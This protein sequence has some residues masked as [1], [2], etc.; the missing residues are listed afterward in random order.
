MATGD[1]TTRQG[2]DYAARVYVA[3]K[4]DPARA[5]LW[6]RTKFRVIRLLYRVDPPRAV[7]NYIWASRLPKGQ[8]MTSPHFDQ[9]TMVAVESGP[10]KAGRWVCEGRNV[11]DDYLRLFGEAPTPLSG[12]AIMT[13]TDNTGEDAVAYYADL[14]LYSQ[15]A[16]TRLLGA[17]GPAMAP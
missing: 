10:E 4:F 13:D 5:T 2:D 15:E 14:V 16:L 7:I 3:F 12:V 8:A 9:I 17:K 6:E 1:E 11:Y